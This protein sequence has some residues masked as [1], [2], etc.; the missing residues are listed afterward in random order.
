MATDRT[1]SA[2]GFAASV[3]ERPLFPLVR[4]AGVISGMGN[5]VLPIEVALSLI[6]LKHHRRRTL[7]GRVLSDLDL[8][9]DD[10]SPD[11]LPSR[12]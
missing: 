3:G 9:R 4:G 11:M 8:L 10:H 6:E 1:T 7:C 12:R 2:F 5:E